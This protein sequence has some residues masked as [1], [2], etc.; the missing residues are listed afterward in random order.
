[1]N[2]HPKV[3]YKLIKI[4]LCQI[5]PIFTGLPGYLRLNCLER[6]HVNF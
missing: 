6:E 2:K 3:K 1:M 4:I 5:N